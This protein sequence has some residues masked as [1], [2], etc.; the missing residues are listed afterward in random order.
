VLLPLLT[1]FLLLQ[2]LPPT[3][4]NSGFSSLDF[5]TGCRLNWEKIHMHKSL[6]ILLVVHSMYKSKEETLHYVSHGHDL[7][8][9]HPL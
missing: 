1:Y 4:P 9:S 3:V 8:I 5:L 6:L 7:K 2:T